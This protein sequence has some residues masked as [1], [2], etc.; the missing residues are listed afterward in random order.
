MG[1]TDPIGKFFGGKTSTS[2][3]Q[4]IE[5]VSDLNVVGAKD[6][7]HRLTSIGERGH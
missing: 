3:H 2:G 6:H 1:E 5:V 7:A 4:I